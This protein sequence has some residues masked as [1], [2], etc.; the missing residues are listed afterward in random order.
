MGKPFV[1]FRE[2]AGSRLPALLDS[3]WSRLVPRKEGLLTGDRCASVGLR[4]SS[5][6]DGG[7]LPCAAAVLIMS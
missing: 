2:G 7:L 4:F 3:D 6:Q 1:R 5:R